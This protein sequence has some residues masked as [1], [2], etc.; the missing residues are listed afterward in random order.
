VQ[1]LSANL[2]AGEEAQ[3]QS[4]QQWQQYQ[5]ATGGVGLD[6]KQTKPA[7]KDK[8]ALAQQ[9]QQ[10]RPPQQQQQ[11]MA[12]AIQ[13]AQNTDFMANIGIIAKNGHEG[14][15]IVQIGI[16]SRAAHVGLQQ[17]DVIK[18]VDGNIVKSTSDANQILSKKQQGAPVQLMI[19][20]ANQ[21]GQFSL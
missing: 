17:G 10:Q 1:Q 19:Q 11:Y 18:A 14:L 20:R 2:K 7:K 16:A 21:M 3:K 5:Q 6:G 4:D 15:Q 13:P 8:K 12:P 9:P